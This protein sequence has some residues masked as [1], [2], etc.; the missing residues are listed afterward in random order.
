MYAIERVK[1][2]EKYI[3]WILFGIGII[4]RVLCFTSLPAGL[5]QDEAFAGYEAYSLLH[6]GIDSAGNVNPCH[7][8][9]WGSGM[10]VL[11]SYLMI[12]FIKLFGLSAVTVRLPQLLIGIASLPIM[13]L[14]LKELFDLKTAY[15]GLAVLAASPWHIMLSRWALESNLAP[16]LLLMGLFFFIKAMKCPPFFLPAA[17]M[18]GLSL[19]AYAPLW[20]L[21]PVT[22][23]AVTIYMLSNKQLRPL[24]TSKYFLISVAIVVLLALPIFLFLLVNKGVI[25]EIRLSFFTIPKLV[26]MRNDSIGLH[27]LIS[28]ATYNSFL[29]ILFKQTD[30]GALNTIPEFGLF[31]HISIPFMVLGAVKWIK[32][33]CSTDAKQHPY[34]VIAGIAFAAAVFTSLL[35]T[36][37]NINRINYLH[38]YLAISVAVGLR[39]VC[40]WLKNYSLLKQSLAVLFTLQFL[41]FSAYYF[42]SYNTNVAYS[43]L[44]QLDQAVAYAKEDHGKLIV[45]DEAIHYPRI[46]F[47]DKTPVQ[48]FLDTVEYENYPSPFL[49][50]NRF[51][52]FQFGIDYGRLERDKVYLSFKE[53][54]SE[55]RSAGFTV[56]DFGQLIVAY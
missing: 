47:Y 48:D 40:S 16:G 12:P 31:Y 34:I 54:S 13:Y 23:C 9:S 21:V 44:P 43:F 56:T 49:N 28:P 32:L 42:S 4:V 36:D 26:E 17:C 22:L 45:L 29:S 10:N 6:Y 8:V 19:Y 5:N 51:T 7:F 37:M 2:R 15:I 14:L 35:I 18:Y 55:F 3:F 20:I 50:V 30:G 38:M 39:Q 11:E 53:Y 27:N 41:W 24:L 33:I 1:A 52:R 25:P 46:L